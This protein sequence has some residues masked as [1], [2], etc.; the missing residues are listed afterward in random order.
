MITFRCSCGKQL[1]VQDE[2][3]GSKVKCPQCEEILRVPEPGSIREK[4]I[5]PKTRPLEDDEGI[6][7]RP[8]R[9]PAR[10]EEDQEDDRPRRRAA[11]D[12]D[13]DNRERRRRQ[14]SGGK[15]LLIG[16]IVGGVLFLAAGGVAVFFLFSSAQSRVELARDRTMLSNNIKQVTLALHSFNDV[17]K[18]LPSPGFSFEPGPFKPNAKPLLSWRVAILPYVEEGAL[19]NQF[20]LNEPWDGPNNIQ[21]LNRMPKIFEAI[22]PQ[23]KKEGHTY[24]QFVTGPGTLFPTPTS[25]AA[26]PRSFPDGTSNTA[27][28]VEAAE[29]VPWTKPADFSI[30]VTNV[31]QGNV[32]KLGAFSPDGFFAGLGDGSMKFIDRRQVSDTTIR[33][34]FNPADLKPMP[35]DWR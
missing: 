24:L 23:P 31:M 34:A 27:V 7:D 13:D 3:A 14:K 1:K 2:R 10:F 26:I 9:R 32:P 29:P 33:M 18:R 22:G 11:R 21:L 8:R 17:Y 12:E 15:G 28:I 4:P 25:V 20:K 30:D 35:E 6:E 19:Y 16:L 5:P